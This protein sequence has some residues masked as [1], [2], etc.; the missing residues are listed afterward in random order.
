[1]KPFEARQLLPLLAVDVAR[2]Q[3][4]VQAR[5]RARQLAALM[6]F[7]PRDQARIA[8]ATSEVSRN[9]LLYAGR[10]R[11]EFLFDQERPALV[12]RTSDQGPGIRNLEEILAG[13]YVS[14]TGLG[15]GLM[16]TRRLTDRFDVQTGPQGTIVLFGKELPQDLPRPRPAALSEGIGKLPP[17][18]E[19]ELRLA[20]R[21]LLRAINELRARDQE[22]RQLQSELE[23]TNRGVV[24][25]Y[26]ELDQKAESLRK[27]TELKSRFL[28]NM[29]H[30]FRT[31]L[32]SIQSLARILLD[33]S[34]GPL[35]DGQ[36]K[37][38][39]LIRRS[40]VD[41]AEMV[42]DL[43]DLAR[44]EAGKVAVRTSEFDV[45]HLFGSLRGVL[46]PLQTNPGPELIFED[47]QGLPELFT[48]EGKLS[49]ILRNLASNALKFTREGEV[50]IGARV[51]DGNLVF[52]VRDTGIGIAPADQERIF[53]EFTQVEGAHQRHV[54]GTGLGLPLSRKLAQLLGGDVSV[55]SQPGKGS[56]FEVR[57]PP[58]WH[59]PEERADSSHA[60]V[61]AAVD[62]ADRLADWERF[63]EGSR[64]RLV[65]ART[66]DEARAAVKREHAAALIVG[67]YLAGVPTRPLLAELKKDPETR[68]LAVVGV[69]ADHD[70]RGL[71]MGADLVVGPLDERHALLE[72]LARATAPPQRV[73]LISR[74][75][76]PREELRALLA[77]PGLELL[78]ARDAAEGLRRARE[79]RPG[80]VVLDAGALGFAVEL[81]EQLRADPATRAL[82]V[83]VRAARVL[84]GGE[85][86]RLQAAGARVVQ[87][88]SLLRDEAGRRLR[89]AV[90][91]A[92][93]RHA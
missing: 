55:Q 66:L 18:P 72:A 14:Q 44:I 31:P 70:A 6:G 35:G 7:L 51:E 8:T 46:K 93:G 59:E 15:A 69:A 76:E 80:S 61:V 87:V 89:S 24:A 40:A 11:C 73:L 48:D 52:S 68:G 50:R 38:I 54:K 84:S 42:N 33:G 67:P 12:V 43:L 86:D 57:L 13:R 28:S 5:Q 81:V 53:E 82:P 88:Y 65:V 79:E 4:V 20:D 41:L 45:Q 49:Q 62:Q 36:K 34:E 77:D 92:G 71:A 22:L 2:E 91:E 10:G 83:L 27:A 74:E 3:D 78:E 39:T 1:M 19:D 9:A 16:G 60:A 47:A 23:E 64:Y 85:E 58:R 21:E 25:L 90:W 56:L 63:L 26:A 30:E 75:T 29:S 32:N 37:A 17:A